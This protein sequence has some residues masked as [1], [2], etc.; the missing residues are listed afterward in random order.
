MVAQPVFIIKSRFAFA[1]DNKI[2]LCSL[3]ITRVALSEYNIL[4]NRHRYI[5]DPARVKS[6]SD[7]PFSLADDCEICAEWISKNNRKDLH[8]FSE[9]KSNGDATCLSDGTK[10]ARCNNTL[11]CDMEDTIQDVGSK[12]GHSDS[13][14]DGV[15]NECGTDFTIGCGHICHKG[16]IEGFFYKIALFFWK[17]FKTN[18]ECSCGMYHY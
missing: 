16:G 11:Y 2:I 4:V 5:P 1:L 17:L 3:G 6:C 12:K 8:S 13:D 14:K 9:Y 10:T 15:C 7:G 18:K